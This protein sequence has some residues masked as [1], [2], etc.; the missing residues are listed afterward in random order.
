MAFRFVFHG[1]HGPWS[2]KAR[3]SNNLQLVLHP[4]RVEDATRNKGHRYER[5]KDATRT[6]WPYYKRNKDA[7]R[8]KCLTSSNKCHATRNKDATR[9]NTLETDRQPLPIRSGTGR[10]TDG[11]W[12][13]FLGTKAIYLVL[14]FVTVLD[15]LVGSVTLFG[16]LRNL[17]K[18]TN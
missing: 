9:N 17:Q 12:W 2:A 6:S 18:V 10:R 14:Q 5:S 3:L 13:A 8:N 1:P 11:A 15:H 7:T 16:S 4:W